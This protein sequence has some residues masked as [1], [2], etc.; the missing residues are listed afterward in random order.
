MDLELYR[1]KQVKDDT[2]YKAMYSKTIRELPIKLKL[3]TI[4]LSNSEIKYEERVKADRKP[5][6]VNFTELNA[7]IY[8]LT[9]MGMNNSDFPTTN[10]DVE[11]LFMGEANLKVDWNFDISNKADFFRISGNLDRISAQAINQFL[12]PALNVA[13]QGEIQDMQFDYSGN[14][15]KASGQMKLVYTDFKVKVLKKDGEEKSGFLSALANLII[16]NDATS[17]ER[18]QK[19]ITATRTKTKSFWNYLWKMVRNGALKSFL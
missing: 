9:N 12:K 17:E 15:N 18:T 11:T 10:I 8:N 2:R 1:D 16:N 5:G 13:A 6:M 3:D 4:K 7:S 14:K 19:D